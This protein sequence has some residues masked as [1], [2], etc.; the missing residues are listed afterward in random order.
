MLLKFVVNNSYSIKEDAIVELEPSKNESMHTKNIATSNGYGALSTLAIFGANASGKTNIIRAFFSSIMAIRNSSSRQ[1]GEEI[2]HII[3]FRFDKKKSGEPSSFEFTFIADDGIKYIYG[4]SADCKRIYTEYLFAYYSQRPSRI[5]E[6]D[7][8]SEYSYNTSEKKNIEPLIER[9]AE[10]KLFLSTAAQWNYAKVLPAYRWFAYGIDTYDNL[11]ALK[12]PTVAALDADEDG[13]FKNFSLNLLRQADININDYQLIENEM[14]GDANV[15]SPGSLVRETSSHKKY[16]LNIE[17]QHLV[18]NGAK[19]EQYS[20]PLNYE[21]LGTIQLFYFSSAL[22]NALQTGKTLIIDELD[23]SLH[24]LVVE[25]LV[26]I[27]HSKETNPNHAQLI[28]TAHDTNLLSLSYFRRDQIYFTEKDE[29]TAATELYSLADF[30]PR[31]LEN[32][33]KNYLLGRYGAIPYLKG[34]ELA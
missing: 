22:K 17:M 15:L 5:F 32:V 11:E 16:L 12:V 13:A 3:P 2:E 26:H 14:P 25:Y 6:R 4:F 10:N 33:E 18:Y 24:P 9:N 34:G 8:T 21:S 23:K 7:N 30:S 31:K 28:F 27:F 29:E 19:E 1:P 20:L